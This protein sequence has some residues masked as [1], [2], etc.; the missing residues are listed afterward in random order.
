MFFQFGHF[1]YGG[2]WRLI[3]SYLWM[4]MNLLFRIWKCCDDVNVRVEG[5][6]TLIFEFED[7]NGGNSTMERYPWTFNGAFLG[8]KPFQPGMVATEVDFNLY[9][10]W[11]HVIGLPH[12]WINLKKVERIGTIMGDVIDVDLSPSSGFLLNCGRV[13]V[14]VYVFNPFYL[15]FGSIEIIWS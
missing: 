9:P 1:G 5:K 4:T 15:V 13:K 12:D 10:F 14:V 11:I 2:L 6:N 7:A 3:D 8:L